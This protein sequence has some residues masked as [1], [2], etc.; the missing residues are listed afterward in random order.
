M[1]VSVSIYQ[2][3]VGPQLFWT[4]IGLGEYT[5]R[6]HG[7]S[8]SK[9][10]KIIIDSLK[11]ACR[12]TGAAAVAKML[13]RSGTRL[14][15]VRLDLTLRGSGRRR[16]GGLYPLILEPREV[17]TNRKVIVAYHPAR[18]DEWFV[19]PEDVSL[20]LAA[21]RYFESVWR[22]LSAPQTERLRLEG[23]D[24]LNALSF[25]VHR[26]SLLRTLRSE[27]SIWDDLN[28]DPSRE[29]KRNKG[30]RSGRKIPLLKRLGTNLTERVVDGT[31]DVGMPRD[32]QR[33]VL[34]QL[35][36][37]ATKRSTLLIGKSGVGKSTLRNRLIA[38][39]LDADDYP[40]HRNL[41]LVHHVWQLSAKRLIAGM[42]YLG[43]WEQRVIDVLESAR[44]QKVVLCFDDI[45]TFGRVGRTRGS[46][47]CFA[48]LFRGP[49]SRGE[50]IV[51][52]EM[53]EAQ[54][55][56]L[57]R[58]VP[59]FA[60]AFATLAVPPTDRAETIRVILHAIRE[61][62]LSVDRDVVQALVELVPTLFPDV[63][64]PGI[65]VELLRRC[66]PHLTG[67][68][69][70]A[71]DGRVHRDVDQVIA[72]MSE[73]TGLEEHYITPH[74]A[75][76]R[77][78]LERWLAMRVMGQPEAVRAAADLSLRVRAGL[79]D[80]SRPYATYLFTGPTGTGKTEMCK[81]IDQELYDGGSLLRFD[82]GEYSGPDAVARLIGDR[83]DP[84]GALT[85]A[86]RARETSPPRRSERAVILS[87]SSRKTMPFC[88]A[89]STASRFIASSSI[90]LSASSE[91][92]G[93]CASLIFKLTVLLRFAPPNIEDKSS[94]PIEAPA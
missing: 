78:T 55:S 21:K 18:Q 37:G 36:V 82:M 29:K 71:G 25:V 26:P 81:A 80:P 28:Y 50:V 13:M 11:S 79:T 34:S 91:S 64:M 87:I 84:N 59:A 63:A 17:E 49:V 23:R 19:V 89:R 56:S 1:N 85:S 60:G 39:M 7:R 22:D 24:S 52:G 3:K 35:L 15:R 90:S 31:L 8:P 33:L 48:D 51:I 57:E 14:K 74:E 27:R 9:L 83:F 20:D 77:E 46:D 38:D 53:T 93:A 42:S 45:H 73:R 54:F 44:G 5:V 43:E 40:T 68:P 94:I 75:E 61:Q 86:V 47:R 16:E 30:N 41:D 2:R 32:P 10:R 76:S 88:S 4:T 58:D 70:V 12:D 62:K 6:A 65:A 72:V 66:G 69:Y 67:K 92:N